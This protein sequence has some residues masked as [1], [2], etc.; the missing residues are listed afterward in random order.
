MTGTHHHAQ[1]RGGLDVCPHVCRPASGGLEEYQRTKKC[2]PPRRCELHQHHNRLVFLR[3]TS[4]HLPPE[5]WEKND[6]AVF[7]KVSDRKPQCRDDCY[8]HS[9]GGRAETLRGRENFLHT[10]S[11]TVE[12]MSSSLNKE[13]LPG[14]HVGKG[15][16]CPDKHISVVMAFL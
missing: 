15:K 3:Y 4:H 14:G 7:T 9:L 13:A 10:P 6:R 1:L 2:E 11:L 16:A 5:M 8:Q 12:P